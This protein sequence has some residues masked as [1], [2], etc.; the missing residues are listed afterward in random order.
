M[1]ASSLKKHPRISGEV[2]LGDGL[3]GGGVTLP[4]PHPFLS[5]PL[6]RH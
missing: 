1:V 6:D 4:T 5:S 3:W 2:L